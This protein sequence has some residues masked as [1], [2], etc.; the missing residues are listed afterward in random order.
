MGLFLCFSAPF[1]LQHHLHVVIQPP[2][3][4]HLC[5]LCRKGNSIFPSDLLFLSR[6]AL[7]I[8]LL[9][10]KVMPRSR[11]EIPRPRFASCEHMWRRD[12]VPPCSTALYPRLFHLQQKENIC[13]MPFS[14]PP[15]SPALISQ[16]MKEKYTSVR[17]GILSLGGSLEK[18]C[19]PSKQSLGLSRR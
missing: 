10:L 19:L 14:S 11:R 12:A 17:K 13:T 7:H 3:Q 5:F 8:F 16:L 6:C 2:E 18:T 15:R 4:L 1:C 9:G